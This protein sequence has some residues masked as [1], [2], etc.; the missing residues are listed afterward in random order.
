MK[1]LS[2]KVAVVTGAAR[3]IGRA[4]AEHF[5]AEGMHVVLAD[6]DAEAVRD[7]ADDVRSRGVE[8]IAVPTDVADAA[9]VGAL[10]TA[11]RDHFGT[12]HVVCNNAGVGGATRRSWEVPVDVWEWVLRVNVVGVVNG[13]QAFVPMLLA[14]DEGHIVNTSSLTGLSSVPYLA[15][16]SASKHAVVAISTALFHELAFARANVGV[17]VVCPGFT[18][19]GIMTSAP[20]HG[21]DPGAALVRETFERGVGEG[22]DPSVVAGL[23]VEAVRAGQ[24]LVTTHRE[25]VERAL[26]AMKALVAGGLPSLVTLS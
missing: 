17:T 20:E 23:T 12:A 13:I 4:L 26:D 25:V 1:Q 14:Q 16:Y 9:A 3:G 2:G 24:F 18:R 10:A 15:P 8:A 22:L 5:A 19:T 21:D 6:L 7:A 11:T